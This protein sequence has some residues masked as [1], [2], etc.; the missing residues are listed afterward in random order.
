M[1]MANY[2]YRLSEVEANHEAYARDRTIIATRRLEQLAKDSLLALG[3][4][5]PPAPSAAEP[6]L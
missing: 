6:S 5:R 3:S 1:R 4:A 2:V